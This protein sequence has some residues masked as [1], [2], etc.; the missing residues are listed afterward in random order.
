MRTLLPIYAIRVWEIQ[1]LKCTHGNDMTLDSLIV[2]L[3]AFE[4]SKFD[5]PNAISLPIRLSKVI[6]LLGVH[7]SSWIADTL[8][9]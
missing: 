2:R 4:L 1:E 3:D 8:I 9:A 6:S 5:N 7:L